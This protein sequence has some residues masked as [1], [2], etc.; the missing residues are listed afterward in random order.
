MRHYGCVAVTAA[1]VEGFQGLGDRPNLVELDED[2]VAHALFNAALPAL[3]VGDE[4][5][6]AHQLDAA[7]QLVSEDLPAR[8]VVLG[9]AVFQGD[10]WILS[11]PVVVEC[12][13][14]SVER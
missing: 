8:P 10:N 11:G 6:V 5:V 12:N 13:H 2:G 7:A 3:D 14:R 4:N 9:E 1:Q